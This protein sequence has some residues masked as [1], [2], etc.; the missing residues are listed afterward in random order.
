MVS[1]LFFS[2][3]LGARS[4]AEGSLAIGLSPLSSQL[5]LC[6]VKHSSAKAELLITWYILGCNVSQNH[7][8]DCNVCDAKWH[9]VLMWGIEIFSNASGMVWSQAY[10]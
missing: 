9:S 3:V 2:N 8:P 5:R 7:M 4:A 10:C 1:L 6:L